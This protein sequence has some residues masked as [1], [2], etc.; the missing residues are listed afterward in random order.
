MFKEMTD[1]ELR[2]AYWANRTAL[3]NGA[4]VRLARGFARL[5]RNQDII[6]A[7]ARKRGIDL[8]D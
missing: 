2:E 5:L 4:N 6:V 3:E 8:I 1:T 7:I